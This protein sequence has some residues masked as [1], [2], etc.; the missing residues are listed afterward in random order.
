M[1]TAFFPAFRVLPAF[2]LLAS[3]ASVSV[4]E[5]RPSASA[6]R[7]LPAR[8]YVVD[9]DCPDEVL[10]VD[11]QGEALARFKRDLQGTLS[12]ALAERLS[13]HVA[14]AVAVHSRAQVPPG[15][16]WVVEGRF[17]RVNQGSRALRTL[18]GFGA[19]GTKLETAVQ[20]S[21]AGAKP[22]LRFQTT[23]GSNAEPGA[24]LGIDPTS[25]A[26]AGAG[27]GVAAA[28]VVFHG[29]TE[30][31]VRTSRMITAAISE[32]SHQRGWIPEKERLV[33]KRE[34]KPSGGPGHGNG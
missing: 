5:N 25:A 19:G 14:P 22:F 24:I 29:V 4:R 12:C 33:P 16:H 9:F 18:V 20:V 6:P 30:D 13:K 28:T 32:Y 8:I 1:R 34:M 15:N 7:A 31:T 26:V 11:R 2:L 10:R 3:C 17:T 23:G 21:K 27:V